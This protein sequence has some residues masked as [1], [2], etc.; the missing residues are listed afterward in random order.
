MDQTS[1]DAVPGLG[2]PVPGGRPQTCPDVRGTGFLVAFQSDPGPASLVRALELFWVGGI[3]PHTIF[4]AADPDDKG[5]WSRIECL[6]CTDINRLS[7]IVRKIANLPS[8]HS[9]SVS[10]VSLQL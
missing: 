3:A 10:G 1:A 7:V 9:V 5:A 8:I 2:A 6:P 4:F